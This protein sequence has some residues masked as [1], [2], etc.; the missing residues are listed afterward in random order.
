M[1]TV[2][3][4]GLPWVFPTIMHNSPEYSDDWISDHGGVSHDKEGI[5]LRSRG[6][7]CSR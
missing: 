3:S 7:P 2:R 5:R 1:V 4:P 6:A